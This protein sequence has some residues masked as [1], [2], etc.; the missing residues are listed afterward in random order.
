[1]RLIYK[2]IISFLSKAALGLN[3]TVIV[4]FQFSIVNCS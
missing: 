4:N 2:S 1:M 3:R